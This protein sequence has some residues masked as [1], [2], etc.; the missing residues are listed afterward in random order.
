[1]LKW[2]KRKFFGWYD[3]L[4]DW[5]WNVS[6]VWG[7]ITHPFTRTW[8]WVVK[9]I[10]YSKLLWNDFDWDYCFILTLLKY[11]LERTRKR[12]K[13]NDLI[14]RAPIIA[15]EILHVEKLIDKFMNDDFCTE[16][17]KAHDKKWGE[18]E[19]GSK[20]TDNSQLVEMVFN[21]K[22]VITDEDKEQQEKEYRALMNKREQEKQECWEEIFDSM[23]K[24]MQGWWD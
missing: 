4:M 9:S 22:H 11:K 21:R 2:I 19:I 23:K 5:K 16:E 6:N 7:K 15:N 18:L 13:E 10:Q 20:P 14:V 1:M 12:I 8:C 24:Y 17:Q 3:P